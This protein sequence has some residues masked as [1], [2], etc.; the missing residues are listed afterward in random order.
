MFR[1]SNAARRLSEGARLVAALALAA[2][3]FALS[4]AAETVTVIT[5]FPKE[6]TA[7]YKKA[8]EAKYPERQAR[9]PQQEHRGRHRLRARAA[10]GQPPRD[11]LGLG[12]RRLRGARVGEAAAEDRRAAI[13]PCRPRSATIRST[14]RRAS[15]SARRSPAT[16]SCGTR[17]TSRRTSCPS[18][19]NGPTSPSR[20]IS[21]TSRSRARRA[22]APRTSRSRRSCR[23]K[24]GTRA[25]GRCWRSPATA[26]R[27][28]SAASACR[29][30]WPA[31]S[32]ASAS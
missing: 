7:A 13:P 26:R 12:A 31:A 9:D 11:V 16:A 23:A 17:A 5:S 24:A 25:G 2:G 6:L 20:S 10:G 32:S 21:A 27:S 8:Y 15:T 22:R 28:P 29:T 18:R 30:A 19:R 4:A 1:R 14:I 3:G